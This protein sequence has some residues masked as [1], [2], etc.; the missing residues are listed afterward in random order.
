MQIDWLAFSPGPAFFGGIL[1][2]IAAALYVILHGRILGI[3]GIISGLLSPKEGDVSWR[4]SLVLGLLSA[5]FLGSLFFDLHTSSVIDAE[6]IAIIIAGLLVGFG[7]TYG[8]GCTSG[9][10]VC[11]LSRLSPRSLVAT[12]SFMGAGFLTVFVIRHILGL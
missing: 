4:I 10:G 1:L 7:S 9:H 5:P 6:W 11:G 8:S 12:L 2:G 3:S